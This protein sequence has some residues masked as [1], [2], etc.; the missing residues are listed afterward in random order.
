MI[1]T[2]V[3]QIRGTTAIQSVIGA[4]AGSAPGPRKKGSPLTFEAT[5]CPGCTSRDLD[6]RPA[7]IAPFIASYVFD[8]K[9]GVCGLCACRDCGLIFFA[10]RYEDGEIKRL[11]E[12]YR[13]AEY[14]AARHRVEPWYTQKFNDDIGGE[15]GMA[16]RRA[17]Y[18]ATLAAHVD[19]ASI[20]TVLDYAG[21]RGQIMEGGPGRERFVFDISGVPP[22]DGVTGIADEKSL[23]GRAFDLVLLCGVVEHFSEP[24][25]QVE[26][27]AK[28]VKPGGLLYL[29]VPDEQYSIARIPTG[30]WYRNYLGWIARMRLPLLAMDF[31]STAVRV[32]FGFIPPLG[33]AKQHEHLNYFDVP[34][35]AK[36]ASKAGLEVLDC[37]RA[38]SSGS[39]VALCRKAAA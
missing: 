16:P 35:L 22:V 20:G 1:S 37:F 9:P 31:W 12:G 6:V 39:I 33:F 5:A 2:L 21:D 18:Q 13:E 25:R 38:T 3:E 32:K 34:S 30:A 4:S 17:V 27:T 26:Q 19:A 10:T 8:R 14:F 11:Y 29:E 36:L 15:A 28:Y 24:L 7:L 23:G